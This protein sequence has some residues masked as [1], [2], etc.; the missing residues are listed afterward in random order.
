MRTKVSVGFSQ[1]K[2]FQIYRLWAYLQ[3]FKYFRL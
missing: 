2:H 3:C 1:N